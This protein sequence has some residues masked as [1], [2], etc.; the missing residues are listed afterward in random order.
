MARVTFTRPT[1]W[2]AH[3]HQVFMVSILLACASTVV[4]GSHEMGSLEFQQAQQSPIWLQD[5]WTGDT[6]L[7]IVREPDQTLWNAT[8]ITD[9]EESLEVDTAPPLGVLT[10]EYSV[11]STNAGTGFTFTPNV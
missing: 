3:I 6:L 7:T 5:P 1:T 10:I 11:L 8:R 2:P 4:A 9:Y